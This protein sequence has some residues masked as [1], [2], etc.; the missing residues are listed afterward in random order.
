MDI[1]TPIADPALLTRLFSWLSPAF[2]IGGFAYSQGLE[3]AIADGAIV[4]PLSLRSWIE[5]QLH[6]GPIRADA[7]FLAIAAQAI[8]RN[9]LDA[10]LKARDLALALQVSSERHAEATEQAR[11][12]L[13]AAQA[14]PIATPA[15]IAQALD[16]PLTLP[17]AVGAMI[18][19]HAITLHH[20]LCGFVNGVIG[21]QISVAVR[22]VPLGQTD[23]LKLLAGLEP[24]VAT[25]ALRA[26]GERLDDVMSVA[27]GIDIASL[28][29]ED[30]TVRIFRS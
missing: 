10:F 28:R 9:D 7:Y 20:A 19:L 27:Y 11:S 15:P 6:S 2:P 21:Q 24:Q 5:G 25:L 29:H 18:G 13:T 14:W 3:R 23:G 26:A 1:I 17:V 4:S 12:F 30:L 22:L 16:A 8:G